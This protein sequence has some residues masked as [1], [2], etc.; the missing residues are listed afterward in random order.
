[1]SLKKLRGEDSNGFWELGSIVI[2]AGVLVIVAV[3]AL[4]FVFMGSA[5]ASTAGAS[6]SQ[7][8]YDKA[9]KDLKRG[10]RAAA[11]IELKNAIR[12]D[13]GNSEA[14]YE[15]A[16]LYLAEGNP[17][18]ALP[19]LESARA[20][21]Y[22]KA[23]IAIPL[24]Q[25]YLALGRYKDAL[26]KIETSA[27]TGEVR[28]TVLAFQA[29]A[30]MALGNTAAAQAL[31]D[32]ALASHPNSTGVII[33]SAML[34]NSSGKLR[35]S[36]AQLASIHDEKDKLELLILKG[37]LRQ[38][39]NDLN[40]ALDYYNL[41]IT[42][43]PQYLG[44]RIKRATLNI[45]RNERA[46]AEADINWVLSV[47]PR[48]PL[49]HFMRAYFLARDKKY[50]DAS[51]AILALPELLESYPP[52]AYLLA[53]TALEDGQY[54]VALD[55]AQ[56][57]LRTA[58]NDLSGNRLLALVHQRMAAPQKA[59]V[60][61]EPL[62]KQYPG[63]NPL[64]LQLAG[65]LLASGQSQDAVELFQQSIRVDSDN[66]QARLALAMGQLRI[67]ETDQ[68]V[69]E[70]EKI[71]E[72]EPDSLQANTL[73]ILMHLQSGA[74]DQA[75][76]VAITMVSKN[77]KNQNAYNLL[78]TVH[79]ARSEY[80][81]ARTAF[82]T[83][84]QYEP[85]SIP[86]ALNIARLEAKVGDVAAAKKNYQK[87]LVGDAKNTESLE[88]LAALAIR[89]G[90]VDS[91]INYLKQAIASN[92]AAIQPRLKLI[93]LLLEKKDNQQALIEA[94]G[95][96]NAMPQSLQ[97]LD[98]LGRAQFATGDA[99]GGLATYKRMVS[100]SP[101]NAE[102]YRRLG[103]AY[104]K[105]AS[106]G[107]QNNAS[108]NQSQAQISFDRAIMLSPDDTAT[109]SDR[110]EFE[111]RFKNQDGA[112][113]LA[114][115]YSDERPQ[116]AARFVILGD[117]QML[118]RQAPAALLSYQQAWSRAQ[119]NITVL[120]LYGALVQTGDREQGTKV[121]SEW[122]SKFPTDYDARFILAQ[123]H[124]L[125]GRKAEA[126]A[127]TEAVSAAFPDNPVLLN[128]LA[129]LYGKE[130]SAKALALAER[131]YAIAPQSPDVLDTLG[132]LHMQMAEPKKAEPLLQKA[133]ESAPSRRDIGFH[134][135]IALQ[136]NDKAPAA[137][138]VLQQILQGDSQF[139]ER[140]E[141]QAALNKLD[142]E[143]ATR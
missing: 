50:R 116:S 97:A 19:E 99:D 75:L 54:E 135:A 114:Q 98:G 70:I 63:D 23:K 62:A 80:D 37:E 38:K 129:W 2:A 33:A 108:Q 57:Y 100:L 131:A 46:A 10:D 5:A 13:G 90:Q 81:A 65:A 89:E 30:Q 15:L 64:Q 28:S 105:A 77:A 42:Q 119:S 21:N 87:I 111:R 122:V 142:D 66:T 141:A 107:P 51:Q 84:L 14:R 101:D 118:A 95:F 49:A 32:E 110:I 4:I 27:L 9:L 35:E 31:V 83:A 22:D 88:G 60:I 1:M 17:A 61:L 143:Y 102:A 103:R 47:E 121:L 29:R 8:Y 76:R 128:N 125:S 136:N 68:G 56:R 120:R 41:A 137:K 138:L 130:N 79:L 69:A 104:L 91:A 53:A 71:I 74:T 16:Q 123:D 86:A 140:S 52:A 58:P 96:V 78:G 34:M 109:L 39:Q 36:E 133:F 115:K 20:R 132:W 25:S 92:S 106:S 73:L 55:Y 67:G 12:E 124:T 94:R 139:P 6:E 112:I 59:V 26:M 82:Q 44:A 43:F 93:D 85:T 134:Y 3:G 7:Q 40:G 45:A 72:V 48:H 113:L 127:E 18:A 117:T 11:K 24:A 126:I